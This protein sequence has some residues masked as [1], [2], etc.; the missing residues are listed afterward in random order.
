MATEVLPRGKAVV[1]RITAVAA[2]ASHGEERHKA[3]WV[4]AASGPER[5]RNRLR[6]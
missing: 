5:G 6:W 4:D 1:W 2:L 3:K